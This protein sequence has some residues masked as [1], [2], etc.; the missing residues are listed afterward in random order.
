[1][2]VCISIERLGFLAAADGVIRLRGDDNDQQHRSN[3]DDG[4]EDSRT[5]DD[6]IDVQPHDSPPNNHLDYTSLQPVVR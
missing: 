5:D 3:P 2:F 1:M 6:G 4:D